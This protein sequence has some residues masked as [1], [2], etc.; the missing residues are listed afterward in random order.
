MLR[1]SRGKRRA[2]DT[3]RAWATKFKTIEVC[4]KRECVQVF[5][6]FVAGPQHAS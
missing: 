1:D 3:Q 6:C 4:E 2:I 5:S